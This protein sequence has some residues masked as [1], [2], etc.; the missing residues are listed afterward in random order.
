MAFKE[1]QRLLHKNTHLLFGALDMGGS[2]KQIS[3]VLQ[4]YNKENNENKNEECQ[5]DW[6]VTMSG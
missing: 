2:S 5:P 4:N 3:F 6:M 1:H